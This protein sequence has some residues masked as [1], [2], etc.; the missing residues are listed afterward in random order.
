LEWETSF[1]KKIIYNIQVR[2]IFKIIGPLVLLI[3]IILIIVGFIDFFSSIT[4]PTPPTKFYFF[5]IS[6]PLIF[7]GFV[8][9]S[10]GFNKTNKQKTPTKKCPSCGAINKNNE[11][12]CPYCD[13][14][15]KE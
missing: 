7:V 2:K 4:K 3:G 14:S 8:L 11:D 15:L 13:Y 9:N 12:N 5:F 6:F 10:I 1:I